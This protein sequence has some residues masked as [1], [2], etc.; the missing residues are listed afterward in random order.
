MSKNEG[1][2]Q[3]QKPMVWTEPQVLMRG[4]KMQE[5]AWKERVSH[6]KIHE[7]TRDIFKFLLIRGTLT[8]AGR[9]EV[10]TK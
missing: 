10:E 6:V 2:G 9:E 1:L 7:S 8:N 5:V 3:E 4:E